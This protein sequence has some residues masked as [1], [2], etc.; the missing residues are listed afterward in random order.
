MRKR[1]LVKVMAGIGVGE[2]AAPV[3]AWLT[4]LHPHLVN[5]FPIPHPPGRT[6]GFR[7]S[8][9]PSIHPSIHPIVR[10]PT[11]F[12]IFRLRLFRGPKEYPPTHTPRPTIAQNE[13]ESLDWGGG[14]DGVIVHKTIQHNAIQL[15]KVTTCQP[16]TLP[17]YFG[18][19][20]SIYS[21]VSITIRH[22]AGW[23]GHEYLPGNSKAKRKIKGS[24]KVERVELRMGEVARGEG[25]EGR[26]RYATYLTFSKTLVFRGF[27]GLTWVMH[28]SSCWGKG[29]L[30]G[31]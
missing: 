6:P 22:T 11:S 26:V 30:R 2:H 27:V 14:G 10:R 29:G 15:S 19:C 1:G 20:C 21:R 9:R 7:P 16:E 12:P 28:D 18:Y 25:G 17:E 24:E 31:S 13:N 4:S 5:P 23:G 3:S 8:P